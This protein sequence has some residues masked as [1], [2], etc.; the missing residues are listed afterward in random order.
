M[1]EVPQAQLGDESVHF[2]LIEIKRRLLDESVPTLLSEWP[3]AI[4]KY[5]P[6]TKQPPFTI[7]EGRLGEVDEKLLECECMVSPANS[8]GIMDGG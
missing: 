4:A 3:K 5:F 1:A 6:D 7:I 8:F 2:L